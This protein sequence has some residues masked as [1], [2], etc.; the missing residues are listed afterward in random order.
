M[1]PSLLLAKIIA[2]SVISLSALLLFRLGNEPEN[3]QHLQFKRFF[4]L[5][6]VIL[7]LVA[8]IIKFTAVSFGLCLLGLGL[9]E[10]STRIGSKGQ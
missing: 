2:L 5:L 8:L 1:N 3:A 7:C 4:S 9:I 6:A 10:I